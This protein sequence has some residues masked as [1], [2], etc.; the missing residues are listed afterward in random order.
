MAVRHLGFPG[1][2]VEHSAGEGL[3]RHGNRE[4]CAA[5]AIGDRDRL[6]PGCQGIKAADVDA[7][8]DLP[9]GAVGVADFHYKAG[10]VQCVSDVIGRLGGLVFD[11]DAGDRFQGNRLNFALGKSD[12]SLGAFHIR[13]FRHHHIVIGLV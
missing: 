13:R 2:S 5:S 4:C 11:C 6:L 7:L 12:A 9:G 1:Q 3:L 10:S 8:G